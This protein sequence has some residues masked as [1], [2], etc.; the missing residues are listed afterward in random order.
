MPKSKF[1]W[2]LNG[3]LFIYMPAFTQSV[4]FSQPGLKILTVEAGA[5]PA[6]M[7]GAFAS[8]KG[9]PYGAAYNPAAPFGTPS[10]TASLGYNTHWSNTRIETGYITF[11]KSS[12]F[13]TAGIQ[14]GAVDDI[15]GRG[16]VPTDDFIPFSAHD[17]S[18]KVGAAFEIDSNYVVGFAL[19]LMYEDIDIYDGSAF[20][21]D[22]GLL[23]TPR[24]NLNIGLAVLNFGSTIKLREISYDL[25]TT[26]RGGISYQYR[27]FI[28][29]VDG[30]K[31][32]DDYYVHLGGEYLIE[33]KFFLRAGYRIGYDAKD[34]SAGAGFSSRN[35]R[36]DYAF[37]PYKEGLNDSHL[38]NLTFKL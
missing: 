15:E 27:D 7:G 1:L 14:L 3:L 30:V 4:D 8:I 25:P 36:I 13:I 22:L 29:A 28:G 26:Y 23:M 17:I 38:F 34:F 16:T 19:G 9:D 11:E 31:L 33:G 2:L 24:P 21:F 6:G 12:V 35:I 5:R 32:N 20:N 10:L 37:L 18:A